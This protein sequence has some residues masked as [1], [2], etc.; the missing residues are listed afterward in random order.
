MSRE[1]DDALLR[2]WPLPAIE[3]DG[4]KESRGRVLVLAGSREMPG[5]AILA[6]TAA[7]RAGAGKLVIA[8]P[9]SVAAVV[10]AAVPESRVIALPEASDGGPTLGALP[11]LQAIA[12]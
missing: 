9:P 1:I 2:G 5:A 8:T 11:P 12:S 3:E 7:L 4:D 10:A 6:G